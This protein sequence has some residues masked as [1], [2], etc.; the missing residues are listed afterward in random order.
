[1]ATTLIIDFPSVECQMTAIGN[2]N[3]HHG[4]VSSGASENVRLEPPY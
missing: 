4:I 1:M 2:E 3:Y